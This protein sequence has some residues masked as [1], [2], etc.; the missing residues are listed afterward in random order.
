MQENER[1][2]TYCDFN[3]GSHQMLFYW[4][5]LLYVL[6]GAYP[7]RSFLIYYSLINIKGLNE[8]KQQ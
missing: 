8:L 1:H 5:S 3:L 6:V 2:V 7:S 4:I